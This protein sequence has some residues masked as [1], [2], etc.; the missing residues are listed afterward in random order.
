MKKS[1]IKNLCQECINSY[2]G[3]HGKVRNTLQNVIDIDTGKVQAHIGELENYI[4]VVFKG[5][6]SFEDWIDNL[7]FKKISFSRTIKIHNGFYNQYLEIQFIIRNEVYKI[8]NDNLKNKIKKEIIFTGHSLGGALATIFATTF[9]IPNSCVTFG[10]PRVGNKA[11]VKFFNKKI[12]IKESL[13]YVNEED[14]VC[15]VPT[16]WMGFRHVKGKKKIGKKL[17]YEEKLLYIPRKIFGNPNDHYPEKY[18]RN[19]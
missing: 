15:K 17:S 11:F 3:K 6:D 16:W 14:T 2:G 19:I 18:L 4:V 5:S 8:Y 12:N 7:N 10:S 13:R 9:S 1:I